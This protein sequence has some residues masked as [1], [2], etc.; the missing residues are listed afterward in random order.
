MQM[1]PAT[2]SPD[3]CKASARALHVGPVSAGR[4]ARRGS[5]VRDLL[6]EATWSDTSR[7][8]AAAGGAAGNGRAARHS[9]CRQDPW[10]RVPAGEPAA[11]LGC[12]PPADVSIVVPRARAAFG[13][14]DHDGDRRARTRRVFLGCTTSVRGLPIS[15]SGR[16]SYSGRERA[17]VAD[18]PV[19]VAD[20][21]TRRPSGRRGRQALLASA[22]I[23]S[24]P[25]SP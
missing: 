22:H 16:V 18:G 25:R 12:R 15:A 20:Q 17:R 8:S 4:A 23:A 2:R 21:A 3:G 14:A 24:R 19:K 11:L 9:T 6:H 13:Q 10:R 5:E 7:T 1:T